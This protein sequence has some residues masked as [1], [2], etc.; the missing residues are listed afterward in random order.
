MLQWSVKTK[1]FVSHNSKYKA[2]R[3]W[4]LNRESIA[5]LRFSLLPFC[6]V[7]PM[8]TIEF[9]QW[10]RSVHW[11][12]FFFFSNLL[13]SGLFFGFHFKLLSLH[14]QGRFLSLLFLFITDYEFI[15]DLLIFRFFT[16]HFDYFCTLFCFQPCEPSCT[17]GWVT[18]WIEI[19]RRKSD[20]PILQVFYSSHTR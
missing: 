16:H 6:E 20:S 1:T 13:F 18:N 2:L 3:A 12:M 8:G 19:T 14:C 7:E 17:D 10:E 9:A 11:T 4:K 15:T 5:L